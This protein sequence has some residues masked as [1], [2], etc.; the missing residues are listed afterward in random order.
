MSI[1]FPN[2]CAKKSKIASPYR[3]GGLQFFLLI[4]F[5]R[6]INGGNIERKIENKNK[7][8][9]YNYNR[10]KFMFICFNVYANRLFD[11]KKGLT[12]SRKFL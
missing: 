10:Y 5:F 4:V 9:Q 6:V 1:V 11:L 8:K 2:V 12:I 7:N 3:K